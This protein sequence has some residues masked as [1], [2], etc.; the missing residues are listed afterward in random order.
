MSCF[1]VFVLAQITWAQYTLEE[2]NVQQQDYLNPEYH[3]EAEE[4]PK[5]QDKRTI[6]P[7]TINNYGWAKHIGINASG[8]KYVLGYSPVDLKYVPVVRPISSRPLFQVRSKWR[9]T[10]MLK[11]QQGGWKPINKPPVYGP[12]PP[13]PTKPPQEVNGGSE[14]FL[15]LPVKPAVPFKPVVPVI[16][17]RP[18]LPVAPVTP[19]KPIY[20]VPFTPVQPII[21]S[22]PLPPQLPPA[23]PIL[24]HVNRPNLPVLPLGATFPSPV[25]QSAALKPFILP[26][27]LPQPH[28]PP[29]PAPA[30]AF[31]SV[32]FHGN[33]FIRPAIA[34]VFPAAPVQPIFA[35]QTPSIQPAAFVPSAPPPP[36]VPSP[37]IPTAQTP[38]YLPQ[39]Q[40]PYQQELPHQI[41]NIGLEQ[42]DV[43]TPQNQHSLYHQDYQGIQPGQTDVQFPLHLPTHPHFRPVDLPSFQQSD[44]QTPF[45]TSANIVRPSIGLEPP[46]QRRRE[47]IKLDNEEQGE[48]EREYED[49]GEDEVLNKH[50]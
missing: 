5:D 29:L 38:L 30:P 47:D 27:P 15:Q 42:H 26:Q 36:F 33:H 41:P 25:L 20:P 6:F 2:Q 37:A 19:L 46:F 8:G 40:M 50:K 39:D 24:F 34:P 3:P 9:P 11:P 4:L 22:A 21:P 16:P 48:G 23:S 45:Q 12:P 35:A 49:D 10:V 13:S 43:Q 28:P 17:T 32:E 1:T 44:F 14:V 7:S 31:T 18:V